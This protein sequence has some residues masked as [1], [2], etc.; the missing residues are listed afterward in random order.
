MNAQDTSTSGV[1]REKQWLL[2]VAGI[3]AV[4]LAVGYLVA[5]PIYALVGDQPAAGIEAQ[6]AYFADH[7][8][9][10]W[11]IVVLMVV[12]DLLYGVLDPRIRLA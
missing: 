3:A 5:I 6:L 9:G 10:W 4:V 7:A 12:T 2:R 11:S 1:D 8:A